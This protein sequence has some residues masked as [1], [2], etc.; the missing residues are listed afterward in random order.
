M[1]S[2]VEAEPVAVADV[3]VTADVPANQAEEQEQL[4]IVSPVHEPPAQQVGCCS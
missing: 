4:S 2:M 1:Q 3:Q